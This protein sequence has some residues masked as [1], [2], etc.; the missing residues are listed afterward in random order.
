[1]LKWFR[2]REVD[3]LARTIAARLTERIP[4]RGIDPSDKKALRKLLQTQHSILEQVERF[5]REH[6]LNLYQK[7]S[8]G[9]T[10]KWVLKEAGYPS[11]VIDAWTVELVAR[12]AVT[13]K[14]EE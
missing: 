12:L 3:E 11:E 13:S 1:M 14:G 7:A 5:A 2:T 10:F 8:F 9:N 4:Y 6:K